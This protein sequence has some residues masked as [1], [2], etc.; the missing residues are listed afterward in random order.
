MAGESLD[1]MADD[2]HLPGGDGDVSTHPG[3]EFPLRGI[4]FC[5]R[6]SG[7]FESFRLVGDWQARD[8]RELRGG[9]GELQRVR[10]GDV[11]AGTIVSNVRQ[12]SNSY[13]GQVVARDPCNSTVARGSANDA[14]AGNPAGSLIEVETGT[15]EG[16]AQAG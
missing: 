12:D 13:I 1:S 14:F 10:A 15:Q 9:L 8:T 11:I 3:I 7:L 2:G 4:V 5:P 16:I 6:R